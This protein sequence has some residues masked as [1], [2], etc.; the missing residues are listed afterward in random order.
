MERGERRR[1]LVTHSAPASAGLCD[2][3]PVSYERVPRG[4]GLGCSRDLARLPPGRC[5]P[6]RNPWL[7][8]HV[9]V[10]FPFPKQPPG[11][12]SPRLK[13]SLLSSDLVSIQMSCREG[14]KKS[15]Y[16]N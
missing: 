6:P 7:A 13:H 3:R 15:L 14:G 5:H 12:Q 11:F 9:S 8:R 1:W 16:K 10:R 2:E 4:R